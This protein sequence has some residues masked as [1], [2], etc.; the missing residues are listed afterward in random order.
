MQYKKHEN[1]L[2]ASIFTH[3]NQ[4]SN[5]NNVQQTADGFGVFVFVSLMS[6]RRAGEH[7]YRHAVEAHGAGDA[8]IAPTGMR[9]KGTARAM[10]A[11]PLLACGGSEGIQEGRADAGANECPKANLRTA[12]IK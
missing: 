3:S 2:P 9:G 11:S 4:Q 10:Q 8:G 1:P 7:D 12:S 5:I 6:E